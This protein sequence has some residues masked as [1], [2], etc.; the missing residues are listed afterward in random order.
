MDEL[1]RRIKAELNT[2]PTGRGYAGKTD[3]EITA[4]LNEPYEVEV[5]RT[6]LRPARINQIL[7]GVANTPNVIKTADVTEA[8]GV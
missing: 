2:D 3:A 6:E 7:L 5:V 1:M 8:K 4:M